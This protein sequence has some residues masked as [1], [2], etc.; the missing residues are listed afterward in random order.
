MKAREFPCQDCTIDVYKSDGVFM[1]EDN[2]WN[3]IYPSTDGFLCIKCIE[4]RL[5]REL[6]KEDF[7]DSYVNRKSFGTKSLLL[8]T[9]L[10]YITN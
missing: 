8:S 9:R 5:G 3:S 1:L 4:K 7:N 10:D 6:T 2:I